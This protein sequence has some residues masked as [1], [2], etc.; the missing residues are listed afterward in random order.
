MAK[1][2]TATKIVD[3]RA[4]A[5]DELRKHLGDLRKEQFNLRIQKATGQLTN[6]ARVGAVRREVAKVLTLL[7][8]KAKG[9]KPAPKKTAK[10]AA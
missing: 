9:K 2:S 3:L 6:V 4:K 5:E 8:E 1:A 7:N 10:K